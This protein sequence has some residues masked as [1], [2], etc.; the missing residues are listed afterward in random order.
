M[1][2]FERDAEGRLVVTM[3]GDDVQALAAVA[4]HVREL[5]QA[6][7]EDNPVTTRLFPRAYSD[8]TEEAAEREWQAVVHPDL[9]LG[10]IAALDDVRAL[11]ESARAVRG[12]VQV[13]L[14][15]DR[16]A[17]LLSAVNDIRL[18]LGAAL[19]ITADSELDDLPPGDPRALFNWLGAFEEAL[20]ELLLDGIAE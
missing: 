19:G 6:P 16:E 15:A 20:V 11:F 2:V 5:L 14:D 12:V 3:H 1:N 17:R 9:A 8:P 10:K 7:P 18:A 4:A 13:T